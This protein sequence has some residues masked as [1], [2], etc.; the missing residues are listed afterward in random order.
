ML[1]MTY[2]KV[3]E[4]SNASSSYNIRHLLLKMLHK[5]LYIFP[6]GKY[7]FIAAKLWY[8]VNW[9]WQYQRLPPPAFYL[10]RRWN[11]CTSEDLSLSR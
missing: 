3:P 5:G 8:V 7:A 11:S 10:A 2:G 1:H 6:E 4:N 9:Q